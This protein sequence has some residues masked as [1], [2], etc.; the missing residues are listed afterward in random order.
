[1]NTIAY[2]AFVASLA[3]IPASRTFSPEVLGIKDLLTVQIRNAS[4][5]VGKGSMTIEEAIVNY[6]TIE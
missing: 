2:P 3:K 5:K 6:G 1:M 4:F